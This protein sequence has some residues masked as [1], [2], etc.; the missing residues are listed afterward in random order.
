[1]IELL[2]RAVASYVQRRS[3]RWRWATAACWAL[4][5]WV[6]SSRPTS[7][8]SPGVLVVLVFNGAH[9][10]LFG[11]LAALLHLAGSV[12]EPVA[13]VRAIA[14]AAAWGAIDETH[15]L[16]V[17]GRQASLWDFATD[18]AGAAL[19]VSVLV[20]LRGERVRWPR[21]TTPLAGIVAAVTVAG[22]TFG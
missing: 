16:F 6:L 22:A 20:I 1:M 17:P 9:V 3:A 21:I 10:V 18:V 12:R 7:G 14:L 11:V 4:V 5:I 15:Q 13:S 8:A 2:R 19:F